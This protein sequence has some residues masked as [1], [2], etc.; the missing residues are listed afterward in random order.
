MHHHHARIPQRGFIHEIVMGVV[1]DVIKR[2][3]E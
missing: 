1:A 3:V 2:D